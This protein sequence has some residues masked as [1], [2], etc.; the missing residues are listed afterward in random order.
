M[1]AAA[2][3]A[4]V[5]LLAA[6]G[7]REAVAG[8]V[9]GKVEATKEFSEYLDKNL[10]EFLKEKEDYY[11]LIEN[12]VLPIQPPSLDWTSEILVA[13]MNPASAPSTGGIE[14]VDIKGAAMK[15]GVIVISP[16]TT[17][18]FK[19]EDP[20]I[21]SLYSP[22][23]GHSFDPEILT[24]RQLRQV[25]FL[26][27]GVY[28][29]RCKMTPHLEGIVIVDPMVMTYK[30]LAADLT[31]LI[32]NLP[33]GKYQ[34]KVYYKSQEIGGQDVE[35][36]DEKPVE[37]L[38][39]LSPPEKAETAGKPKEGAGAKPEEKKEGKE[40]KEG[41]G[42]EEGGKNAKGKKKGKK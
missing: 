25:Q 40:D 23:L 2:I 27:P 32:E 21:H 37:V 41:A 36:V 24:S 28:T 7:P 17:V 12:G 6:A 38:I 13:V 5:F 9:K 18:K 14:T 26:N 11:W 20:F 22:E 15:P 16:K 29:I 4:A 19:N 1:G 30:T 31:F 42:E 35:I 39:K 8:S 3:A 33:P 10:S 34:L